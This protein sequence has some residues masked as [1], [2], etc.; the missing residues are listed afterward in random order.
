MTN[1]TRNI[2]L[3]ERRA[4]FRYRMPIV[5]MKGQNFISDMA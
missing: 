4:Y 3:P 2:D 1:V 5:Q